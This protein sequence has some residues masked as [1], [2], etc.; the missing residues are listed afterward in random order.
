MKKLIALI[1][2]FTKD[3]ENVSDWVS[4]A[5]DLV[6]H[7]LGSLFSRK[8]TFGDECYDVTID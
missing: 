3:I 1:K 8:S 7:S 6:T 5:Q 4:E 2:E